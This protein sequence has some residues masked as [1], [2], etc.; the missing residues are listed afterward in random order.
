MYSNNNTTAPHDDFDTLTEIEQFFEKPNF[1]LQNIDFE[2]GPQLFLYHPQLIFF[3]K[4][5]YLI[6][7]TQKKKIERLV[8]AWLGEID[9]DFDHIL[10]ME[11]MNESLAIMTIKFCWKIEDV[12]NLKLNTGNYEKPKL[13]EATITA[14]KELNW[15]DFELYEMMVRRLDR[16]KDRVF[17]FY[18]FR[19]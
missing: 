13:S 17:V 10:I 16:E 2:H 5:T 3:G 12:V 8:K 4:P 9:R 11:R 19:I 14:M 7:F 18:V 1:Y 15:A 6:R